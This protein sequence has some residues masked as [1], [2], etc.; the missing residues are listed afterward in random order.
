MQPPGDNERTRAP[1]VGPVDSRERDYAK[2]RRRRRAAA[3]AL[4]VLTVVVVAATL[5]GLARTDGS[6]RTTSGSANSGS[7]H[8]PSATFAPPGYAGYRAR[9]GSRSST[10]A[11][12]SSVRGSAQSSAY[13]KVA[14]TALTLAEPAPPAI[15]TARTRSGK[16]VRLLPTVI[17]YP[18]AE[19]SAPVSRSFEVPPTRD[20]SFPLIVFSQGFDLSP[21]AYSGLLTAWAAA[22]YVVADPTYPLTS[23]GTRS[24]VDEADIINHPADLR[25]VISALIAANLDPPTPLH[26]LINARRVAVVGHSDG[27]DVSLAVAA[28]SCCQDANVTAAVILSGAELSAFGGSYYTGNRVPLLVVQGSADTVNVPGCSA[29]LY[30]QAPEPKYYLDLPGAA[31][32]P[33]YVDPGQ[34]RADVAQA[35]IAFLDAYLKGRAPSL[36][37]L[38]H[39]DRLPGGETLSSLPI[40]PNRSVYCPGAP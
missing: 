32:Q 28:S 25:F 13:Y 9:A 7:S 4:T 37:A 20:R 31:H 15:A 29:Q 38:S 14:T 36:E 27:G 12:G 2:Y 22:G 8:D 23:P 39:A 3:M 6:R 17:R 5:R 16:P 30:D 18:E 33:P 21:E 40:L 35:V 10:R 26:G 1:R 19:I 24:G 11:V 34:T